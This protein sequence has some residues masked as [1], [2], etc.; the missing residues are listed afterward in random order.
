MEY[1]CIT[2]LEGTTIITLFTCP[3]HEVTEQAFSLGGKV[4]LLACICSMSLSA[5]FVPS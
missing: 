2:L 4:A 5:E 1:T 3:V